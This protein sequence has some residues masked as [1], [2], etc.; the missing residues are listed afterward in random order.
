[1]F[2]LSFPHMRAR[3][4]PPHAVCQRSEQALTAQVPS[5]SICHHAFVDCLPPPPPHLLHASSSC[6]PCP[7]L[8]RSHSHAARLFSS[9]PRRRLLTVPLLLA[10]ALYSVVYDLEGICILSVGNHKHLF[11]FDCFVHSSPFLSFFAL[12]FFIC[13]SFF[14]LYVFSTPFFPRQ[15]L[16]HHSPLRHSFSISS[17]VAQVSSAFPSYIIV[18]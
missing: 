10:D 1:M 3:P 13:V 18:P 5:L 12:D 7:L 2:A 8:P 17:E 4:N 15:F 16:I 11:F 9:L 6:F 14:G